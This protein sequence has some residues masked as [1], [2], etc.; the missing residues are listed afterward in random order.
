ML[1][2]P[3]RLLQVAIAKIG[4]P[5]DYE[6][7][8]KENIFNKVNTVIKPIEDEVLDESPNKL[9]EKK[10]FIQEEPKVNIIKAAAMAVDDDQYTPI[11]ALSTFNYDWKIKARVSKKNEVKHWKNARSEGD[12]MNIELIDTN[13]D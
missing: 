8:L 7:N 1:T 11:K 6:R 5:R 10:K 4:D 2:R 3:P 9:E 12:L 13:G